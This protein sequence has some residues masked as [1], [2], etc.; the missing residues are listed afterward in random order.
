ML[1]FDQLPKPVPD[2]AP[3]SFYIRHQIE[4]VGNIDR[5]ASLLKGESGALN[6]LIDEVHVTKSQ[7]KSFA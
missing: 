3:G 5:Y 2:C 4:V 1:R 7:T 6:S